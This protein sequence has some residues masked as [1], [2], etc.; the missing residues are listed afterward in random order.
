MCP[1]I[2]EWTDARKKL[3]QGLWSRKAAELHWTTTEEGLEYF[4]GYFEFVA[5]SKFLTGNT[6]GKNGRPPFIANLEWIVKP[7]NFAK[8]VE[9]TYHA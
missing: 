1:R 4:E 9:G 8:I 2:I 6:D 7:S 5:K 3:L